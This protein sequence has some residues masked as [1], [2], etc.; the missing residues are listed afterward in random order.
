MTTNS[1]TGAAAGTAA[2]LLFCAATGVAA[3]TSCPDATALTRGLEPPASH[4]RYL[5]DDALQG[6]LAGSDGERCAAAYI[7]GV[8]E[9][10]GL[11]P[12]GPDGTWY[13][14]VSLASTLNP[15]LPGGSGR[16]LAAVLPGT[17][18]RLRDEYVVIGAHY[19][20]LGMGGTGSL[21]PGVEA[22]HNG[23]DDNASGVAA[24]LEAAR[25]LAA[26][27]SPARS[28]LFVAFTGEEMGLLGSN[29]FVGSGVVPADRMKAML[30]MDMVGRLGDDPLIVYGVDTAEEWRPLVE[31]AARRYDVT[32]AA[33]GEGYGPSDHTSFYT[34]DIPV[35]HFFTNV[36]GDYH[37]PGDDWEKIDTD[38]VQR[39]AGMVTD[40]A[41]DLAARPANLTLVRGAGAPQPAAGEGQT[42]G[43]GAWLGTVPDFTPVE[44]GVLLSGV[45]PGSPAEAAGILAGDVI[46]GLGD[47]DVADL[48]G[49][50]DALRAHKP[51][52]VVRVRYLRDGAE[53]TAEVTLGSRASR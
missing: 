40:I 10:L 17:D 16:N 27:T 31:S 53:R 47:H 23:A 25:A 15:H 21:A 26:G 19:D 39:V 48:Q 43:Y 44:R 38:G 46:V 11:R 33:R 9:R 7:V 34:R 28:V 49:M 4:V 50:T 5:A 6:R 51:G 32:V 29:Q 24:L 8:F 41:R 2:L 30:N 36:H 3:Q 13:H 37:Q 42:R 52:D 45:S 18:P 12:A 35:L 14:E 1:R 20:H 22:V